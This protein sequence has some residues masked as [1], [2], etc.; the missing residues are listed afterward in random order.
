MNRDAFSDELP[1]TFRGIPTSSVAPSPIPS[2]SFNNVALAPT[3]NNLNDDAFSLA[4]A[5]HSFPA[6]HSRGN[7]DSTHSPTNATLNAGTRSLSGSDLAA[8]FQTTAIDDSKERNIPTSSESFLSFTSQARRV[9][10]P[11]WDVV[12]YPQTHSASATTV[13]LPPL[14]VSTSESGPIP[15]GARCPP[16]LHLSSLRQ[17]YCL[18]DHEPPSNHFQG[19]QPLLPSNPPSPTAMSSAVTAVVRLLAD[20]ELVASARN[21]VGFEAVGIL[22]MLQ[23]VGM[24]SLETQYG[25]LIQ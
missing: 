20:P 5:S 12:V 23:E 11:D 8:L 13:S 17:Q 16:L 4:S 18:P 21:A 25:K 6:N 14:D 3:K 24:C 10:L 22:D 15:Q 2:I 19:S 9:S 7:H 1:A